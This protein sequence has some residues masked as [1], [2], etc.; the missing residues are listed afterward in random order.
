[1]VQSKEKLLSQK[2]TGFEEIAIH[3]NIISLPS[4]ADFF[5]TIPFDS[6]DSKTNELDFELNLLLRSVVHRPFLFY[7]INANE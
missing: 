5:F 6:L 7:N 4:S 2:H 3:V 1:M